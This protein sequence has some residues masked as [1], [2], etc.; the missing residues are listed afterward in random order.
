[1][2]RQVVN[3]IG[4]LKNVVFLRLVVQPLLLEACLLV[5]FLRRCDETACCCNA[6]DC[7]KRAIFSGSLHKRSGQ[8]KGYLKFQ[9]A[10]D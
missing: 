9:V 8:K 2:Y 6:E 1:M 4:I 7:Q 3:F 10:F 5:A